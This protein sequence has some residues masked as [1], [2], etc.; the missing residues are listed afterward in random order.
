MFERG[1]W[2]ME[3]ESVKGVK[4]Q[5][6]MGFDVMKVEVVREGMKRLVT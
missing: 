4:R 3:G 5:M 2:W 6:E 1:E